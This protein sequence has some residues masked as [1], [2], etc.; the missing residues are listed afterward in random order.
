[1]QFGVATQD[2]PTGGQLIYF[3]HRCGLAGGQIVGGGA[4]HQKLEFRDGSLRLKRGQKQGDEGESRQHAAMVC[5]R[6]PGGGRCSV[7]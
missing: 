5:L 4:A 6:L 7:A 2:A 1:M 3:E